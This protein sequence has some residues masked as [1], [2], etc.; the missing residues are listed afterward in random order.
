MKPTSLIL[1]PCLALLAAVPPVFAQS[2]YPIQPVPFTAVEVGPGF[3]QPRM[4]TNRKVTVPYCFQRCEETGRISNFVAAAERNP[5]GFQGIYFNDSDVFKIVEGAAYTLALQAD[6]ELDRYLDELIAKFAAAQEDDGYLYTAKTS[7]SK[8]PHGRTPRWTGL[9]G[10]HELY[11]VGHMYEAAVAHYQATGKRSLLEIAIKNADLI[12]KTFGPNPGQLTHVPGHEEIEI[13]LV[14]L[15]RA[16]GDKKYLDLAKFFVDMRGNKEKRESLYG[17][18]AQDHAP[19]VEQSEAVGHA[20]RGGY[21][22]AGVADVAALTGEQAYIDAIGRI[23]QDV[24][25]RKLYLIGSVGQH[26]AGEGYAGAYTL[27]NLKAYNETC[28]AIAL[29]LWNHRMFLLHGDARYADVLER[30]VYN[31]FLAGVSLSGDRFFYPNPL[32]CDMKFR[33]NHGALERSPW[34]DCSCCP[35]NVVRFL[36]SIPGYVYAVRGKDLYVNL[37]LSGKA[38]VKLGGEPVT[39]VQETDYPWSGKI[40]ITVSPEK[41]ADF[42]LRIR[43]PGWVRGQVLPSDLYRYEDATPGDWSIRVGSERA[44]AELADGYAVLQRRWTPGEVVEIDLPMPVRRVLANEAVEDDRGRVAFDRGPLVYCIE[45]ADHQGAVR[46][47]WIPG[48]AQFQPQHRADLLG[49]ITVLIGEAQAVSRSEQ[50]AVESQRRRLTMI[51]YYAWCHRG[52]NE[53][54]VWMPRSQDL[55]VLPPLPTIASRSRASSSHTWRADP[56]EALSDQLE[57]AASNDHGIPRFTWWDHRGTAEWVQYEFA[58]PA[59]VSKV[60]VYW[61]DDTG[62]GQCRAPE[63]WKLLYRAAGQW[64]PVEASGPFGTELDKFNTLQFRPVETDALRIEVQLKTAFSA[65]ILEW[66]VSER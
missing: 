7:G 34:F 41:P 11:N 62:R 51:P 36:P 65:G 66:R 31:G 1:A 46:N 54:V 48:D 55:A 27:T 20:V 49:G 47:V 13:G 43:V 16:T 26:G 18:Y 24:V 6:A 52:E 25:G 59:T 30:I 61:F 38:S 53:M 28:A 39:L 4:E 50:G 17:Q 57:P 21:F 19:V 44:A 5:D 29:A 32:E 40:R 12:A 64:K 22:Y 2:D 60:D 9:G 58:Q 14:R 56:I 15:Y 42:A 8:G 33:F 23:W 35:S 3:W 63:S 37:F 45:G 10:S